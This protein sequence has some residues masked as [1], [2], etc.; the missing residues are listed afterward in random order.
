MELEQALPAVLWGQRAMSQAGVGGGY[1]GQ[2][3]P[4]LEVPAED[5][6][7]LWAEHSQP[8]SVTAALQQLRAVYFGGELIWL[9]M[10]KYFTLG[11]C[12][13]LF[14]CALCVLHGLI[15]NPKPQKL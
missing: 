4:L 10:S 9:S 15:C 13:L 11:R 8:V 7:V 2:Q 12:C 5:E 3:S 6:Q 14:P 1:C